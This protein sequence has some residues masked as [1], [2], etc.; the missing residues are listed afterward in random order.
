MLYVL[1]CFR[2]HSVHLVRLNGMSSRAQSVCI[3]LS[4][5]S[6][7]TNCS[8][9]PKEAHWPCTLRLINLVYG[10]KARGRRVKTSTPTHCI[11]THCFIFSKSK[12]TQTSFSLYS[13]A[14]MSLA[15]A[16]TNTR[17]HKQITQ[18]HSPVTYVRNGLLD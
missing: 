9:E 13:C 3:A 1:K 16:L 18:F 8:R 10:Q 2:C 7:S 17:A 14:Q 4:K 12:S 11:S 5:I 6:P 15:N